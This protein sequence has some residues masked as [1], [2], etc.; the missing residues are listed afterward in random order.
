MSF[1]K[2]LLV[3][4]ALTALAT[5]T[6]TAHDYTVADIH[7]GHPWARATPPQAKVAGAYL[8]IENNGAAPDRL[9][10]G[11]TSAARAVEIHSTEVTDGVMRMRQVTDGLDIPAGETVALAPGGYHLMLIDPV[12]P[13]KAG[14]RVPLTLEFETA[15][16]VEVELAVEAMGAPEPDHA[17][18]DHSSIPADDVSVDVEPQDDGHAGH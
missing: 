5:T 1:L 14:A 16:P 10:G 9:V 18:M 17:T 4:A 12:E 2:S 6:V 13:L 8:S 15:G 7:I 3:G 11:S